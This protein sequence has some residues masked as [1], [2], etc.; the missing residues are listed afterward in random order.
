MKKIGVNAGDLDFQNLKAGETVL[1]SGELF[2]VRD[3][4]L[5]KYFSQQKPDFSL[6]NKILF[7]CG[8]APTPKGKKSGSLGPTTSSRMQNYFEDLFKNNVKALMGKGSIDEK[9]LKLFKQYK[10]VLFSITGGVAALLASK[11]ESSKIVAYEEL[12]PEAVWSL[13]VKDFPA[14]VAIDSLGNSIF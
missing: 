8:P 11:V 14:V 12:G 4:T 2:T 5:K 6:K 10:T 13:V 7:F 9:Y 1:I 3:S